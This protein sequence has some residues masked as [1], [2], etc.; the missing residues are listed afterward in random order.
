MTRLLL[1]A[2]A[3]VAVL[4]AAG[5]GAGAEWDVYPGAGTPIQTAIVGAGAGDTIYVH[6]GTYVENVNVDKRVTL[7]GDGADMVTV[8]AA[9]V[10]DHVFDVTVDWVNISGFTVTGATHRYGIYLCHVDHCNISNNDASNDWCGI[11]LHYSSSNTMSSN[12][13]D[14]NNGNGI[15]LYYSNNNVLQNNTATNSNK[16]CGVQLD[17]SNNNVLQNNTVDSNNV[18]GIFLRSSSNN[19][20]LNNNA[21]NNL[22]GIRLYESSNYN[23]LAGNA[24]NSNSIG[25]FF[26]SSNNN[27]LS[28]NNASSNSGTGITIGHSSSNTLTNNTA[29][30]NIG[31]GISISYSSNNTLTNNNA[32]LNSY[33]FGLFSSSNNNTLTNNKASLNYYGIYLSYFSNNNTLT[34]NTASNNNYGIHLCYSSNYNAI[35]HNNLIG[36]TQNAYD[37]G[38]N[39]WDSGTEGNYYED[40]YT[41]TDSDGDGIGDTPYPI[42]GGDSVDRYPLMAPWDGSAELRVHNLDTGKNFSTIQAAIDDPATHDGHTVTVGAGTYIENVD[43]NKQLTL[44]GAGA[45]VVTVQ[46][47]DAEDHVFEVTASWVNISGFTVTGVSFEAGIYLNNVDHCAIS[48]NTASGNYY[49]IY[50][51]DSDNNTLQNN[52]ASNNWNGIYMSYSNNNMLS[53]NIVPNNY[54]NGIHL[55]FSSGNTLANNTM[56]ENAY[57]FSVVGFGGDLSYY[58]QKIDTSN[59]VDEKPIYYWVGQQ[60]RQI[61]NDAGFVGIVNSTN[62]TVKD[63]V[64]VNN[65]EGVLIAYTNDS[66]IENITTSNGVYGIC[67]DS[68]SNSTILNNVV[69]SNIWDGIYL[70]DSSNNLL[71]NNNV[72][73]NNRHGIYLGYCGNNTIYHNNLINNTQNAYDTGTN[74]WDSGSA[75]NYYSDYTGTDNN[76]D[77]IGDD[78]R[79]IPGPGGSSVD[80]YPLMAPYTPHTGPQD[81]S[82]LQVE[83]EPDVYW[84]QNNRL[85]WVTDWNVINDMSGVP[86]WDHVNTPPASEFDPATYPQGPRFITTGAA[87]DGLLIRQIGDYKVYRIE[88]GRKRHIT[89]PDVMDLKGYSFDD[90]I[91][92]SSEISDMFPLGDPIGIEVDLYFN[93]K[94]DSGDLSHVS[95]FANGETVKSITETTVAEDYTVETYVR[96]IKPDGTG[97]YAYR[98]RSDF[99]QTDDFQFSDTKRSLYPGTWN[100][101]TKTWNWDDYTFDGDEMEGV[102][103]WEF[104]YEDVASGKVLGKDVQ[105]YEFANSPPS[106]DDA[107]PPFILIISPIDGKTVFHD[108]RLRM[109]GT[110]FDLSGIETLTVNGQDVIS[111]QAFGVVPFYA[112]VDLKEGLNGITILAKDASGNHN[113]K[114]EQITVNYYPFDVEITSPN[115]LDRF[116]PEDFISFKSKVSDGTPPFTYKWIINDVEYSELSDNREYTLTKRLTSNKYEVKLEVTDYE[117]YSI[118]TKEM[119]IDVSPLNVDIGFRPNPNGYQFINPKVD[120][121]SW[122]LFRN[123]YGADLVDNSDIAKKIYDNHYR[124]AAKGGSCFGMSASSLALTQSLGISQFYRQSWD[125]AGPYVF[126]LNPGGERSLDEGDKCIDNL[127]LIMDYNQN[128]ICDG[129][130]RDWGIFP[131]FL[132]T[133][134]DWVVFY[135]GMWLDLP[136]IEGTNKYSGPNNA[137]FSIKDRMVSGNWMDDPMV[138]TFWWWEE[139]YTDENGNGRYDLGEQYDDIDGD[140]EISKSGHSVVPYRI[141][142]GQNH[143]YAKVFVYDNNFPGN[144]TVYILFNLKQDMVFPEQTSDGYINDFYDNH[145][146]INAYPIAATS[147]SSTQHKPDTLSQIESVST[148]GHLL[149]TDTPGNHLGCLNGELKEEILGAYRVRNIPGQNDLIDMSEMYSISDFNLKRE[150]YGLKEGLVT[151]S[152]FKPNSLVIADVQVSS[153]SID[154]LRIPVDGSS[155]EFI[156]GEGTSSLSLML[157]RENTDMARLARMDLSG[158]ESGNSLQL[159]FS[160]DD[161]NVSMENGGSQKKC[162]IYLEQIGFNNSSYG[163]LRDI[164]I[165]ENSS[166][167]ITPLDWNDITNNLIM[168][169][170]D[171]GND[172]TIEYTETLPSLDIKPPSSITNPHPTTGT[173]WINWTWANPPDLDFNHTMVYLNGTW[174]TN[175]SNPFYN[176]TGLSPDASYE[177][178]TH[179]VDTSGNVN[180]TWVNQTTNIAQKGDLNQDDHITSA[181]AAITLRIAASGAHDDAAEVSGDGRVT[182][183]D[184]LMILQ[185]AAG[186]IEL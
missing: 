45:D 22:Y 136:V 67:I 133:P 72:L 158:I 169:E 82:L 40:D 96:M 89:Y 49:G 145:F 75:G 33:G 91:E 140:G 58:I 160:C 119:E 95:Q 101:Q 3:L 70:R 53:S 126:L 174:Q 186:R 151:V 115:D 39:Q 8:R 163:Y 134:I 153:T 166:I 60:D 38:T 103:T 121:L 24:A 176:A 35:Y 98:E 104:W 132:S 108:D 94:T 7:I 157:E 20:L 69:N 182:S 125:L 80:R 102:Y 168:V 149:Y 179:T 155:V 42:P 127:P 79:P 10:Y 142:E 161:S 84:F 47:A 62:I 165:E 19:N 148:P 112:Y 83:G 97:K 177:I 28:K 50:L 170:H 144:D 183:L 44:I 178:G 171:I 128:G 107:I 63:L 76:T 137:Y 135:Q 106:P 150:L 90:V 173:T 162:N 29:S 51:N 113:E 2:A 55:S 21:S 180:T 13:V 27:T 73:N 130:P 81:R 164:V 56:S 18:D 185:A 26:N 122:E 32:S 87:S 100:A 46:A 159:L 15:Y 181:D 105:G 17:Y 93:K 43:V 114:I 36:N 5:V 66:R 64:L 68:S 77:G 57:S 11:Y 124:T 154:E 109:Y 167:R 52:T 30:S 34:N 86:G 9:S 156:S 71:Q 1:V 110:A 54:I 141:E 25:I 88:N 118:E 116:T 138:L 65:G 41:G 4:A 12:T 59:T 120:S 74:Q 16:W 85:Y 48:D 172:G 37:R 131:P 143:G 175:T 78:P 6:A 31:T 152:V 139:P 23:T 99:L 117:G 146:R 14:S 184:A 111:V 61:P 123:T 147:L 129:P 92:V